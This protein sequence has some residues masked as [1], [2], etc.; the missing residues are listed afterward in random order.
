MTAFLEYNAD[1]APE[2]VRLFKERGERVLLCVEDPR[3]ITPTTKVV[4]KTVPELMSTLDQNSHTVRYLAHQVKTY[5]PYRE[6]IFV[7]Q[8]DE[9]TVE[10]AVV[11]AVDDG[12]VS[13]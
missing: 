6:A 4:G 13:D 5:D 2:A 1:R 12:N 7:L 10:S 8:F 11:Q 3:E 9:T